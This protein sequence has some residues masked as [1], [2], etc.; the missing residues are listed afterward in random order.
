M[1]KSRKAVE[2]PRRKAKEE[3]QDQTLA[4]DVSASVGMRSE[5]KRKSLSL[6]RLFVTPWTIS[7]WN[8]PD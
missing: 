5:V 3:I 4:H 2:V 1:H 6:V 8:S 7:P